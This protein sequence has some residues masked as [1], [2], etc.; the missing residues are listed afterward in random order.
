[1]SLRR[2]AGPA[3]LLL[4]GAGFTAEGYRIAAGHAPPVLQAPGAVDVGFAQSMRSHHDQAVVMAQILLD[5]GSTRLTGLARAIEQAQLI[6]IGEMKGWLLL[7]NKPV[8]PG[9]GAMDWML[10][11]RTP[12][13]AALR[14]YLVDC[15]AAGGMPGLATSDEL[16]R[17]RSL[18]GD[19]RDRLFLELMIRHHQ[20]ALPMAHFAAHNADL[21][22]VRTLAAQIEVQQTEEI[23][24]MALMAR[25]R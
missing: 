18:D 24:A 4:A 12:P 7:W 16:N 3:L 15:R 19:E 21:P 25:K 22:V 6:E 11:G 9:S 1:V 13:D 8:L 17:L 10:L 14:Q 23:G 5:H 2:F 20:G